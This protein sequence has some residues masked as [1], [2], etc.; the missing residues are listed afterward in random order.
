MEYYVQKRLGETAVGVLNADGDMVAYH[1]ERDTSPSHTDAIYVGCVREVNKTQSFAMIDVGDF[2]A[3]LNGVHK[4][5]QGEYVLVQVVRDGFGAKNPAVH[6]RITLENMYFVKNSTGKDIRFDRAI[7]NGK[8]RKQLESVIYPMVGQ[9]TGIFVK[10]TALNA[11]AKMLREAYKN[12]CDF[13]EAVLGTPTENI[14]QVKPAPNIIERLVRGASTDDVFVAD[15]METVHMLKQNMRENTINIHHFKDG[16]VF[17]HSG[18]YDFVAT[19][20]ARTVPLPNG[21]S[22]VFDGTEAL[23]AIDVNMGDVQTMNKGDDALFRFNKGAC[24]TI[25]HHIVLRNLSGL[26]VIDFVHMKNRGMMK[27]VLAVL[28]SYMRIYDPYGVW[29]I[30]DI[31]K[32]GLVE[33]TRKRTSPSLADIAQKP[34][35]N[36]DK[37][38][39]TI[40]LEMLQNLLRTVHVGT[41]TIYATKGV[42][43]YL[44][45]SPVLRE[46]EQRLRKDIT[47]I[48]Y[49]K[50]YTHWER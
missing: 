33:M 46:C 29:D 19:L 36:R 40:A 48:P 8:A 24:K 45:T 1:L 20:F 25:A 11:S 49:H 10:K 31:T 34:I 27:Q 6:R 41:P 15:D 44:N 4:L 30:M 21:G 32:A 12:I 39:E 23:Q 3:I 28:K 13:L 37:N 22:V 38:A 43:G 35:M 16:D 9:D 2:T 18:I 17:E 5:S 26:I 14:M 47:L 50:N 42:L 7:G